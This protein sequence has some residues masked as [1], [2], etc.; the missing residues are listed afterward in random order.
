MHVRSH[1]TKRFLL[2]PPS[3]SPLFLEWVE[4]DQQQLMIGVKMG[5][6]CFWFY[7]V[8]YVPSPFSSPLL[9]CFYQLPVLFASFVALAC[10]SFSILFEFLSAI[11]PSIPTIPLC[12]SPISPFPASQVTVS[13]SGSPASLHSACKLENGLL[14]WWRV[15][16][17]VAKTRCGS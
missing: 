17:G 13:I 5:E 16:V 11:G 9:F 2:L 7:F 8:L 6:V 4:R 12:L 15:A 3:P 1:S 14:Q 10:L